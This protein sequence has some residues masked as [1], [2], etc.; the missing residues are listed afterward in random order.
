LSSE[1]AAFRAAPPVRFC[2]GGSA[3]KFERCAA[4]VDK[5]GSQEGRSPDGAADGISPA[6]H[7]GSDPWR[8]GY[9]R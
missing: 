2:G 5:M 6:A 1:E 9:G 7:T 4:A 8:R 3:S